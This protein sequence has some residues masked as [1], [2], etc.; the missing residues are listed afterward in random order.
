MKFRPFFR[1]C[2][3]TLIAMPIQGWAQDQD[4][5]GVTKMVPRL[6]SGAVEIGFSAA[7]AAVENIAN[8]SVSTRIGT[9]LPLSAGFAGGEVE[10]TYS[11]INSLDIFDVV[12]GLSWQAQFGESG[13]Y[14][15][16]SVGGGLRQEWLGNFQQA[17]FPVGFTV[18]FRT[19]ISQN[20]AM[21]VEYKLRCILGDASA[22]FT[23]QQMMVGISLLIK[24]RGQQNE[25]T[26]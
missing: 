8:L 15:F 6:Y 12:G 10:L 3:L 13:T 21:R 17:R 2:L 11:H 26:E 20:S 24:N 14:P 1:L 9:F 25:Q 18:G 23:E 16:L 22:T 5:T 19:L 7:L 4:T